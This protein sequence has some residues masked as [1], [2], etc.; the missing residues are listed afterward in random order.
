M[1]ASDKMPESWRVWLISAAM[2]VGIAILACSL[3]ATQIL[4]GSTYVTELNRQSYLRVRVPG[5]RGRSMDRN[6]VPLV[7]NRPSYNIALFMDD[8]GV[9]RSDKELLP[10][11]RE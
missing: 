5:A 7:H 4:R 1:A 9:K 10:K 3:W 2:L 8:L 11:I 6:G